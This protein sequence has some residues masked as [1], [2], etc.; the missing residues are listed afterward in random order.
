VAANGRR[1]TLV[2]LLHGTMAG[3]MPQALGVKKASPTR[4]VIAFSGDGGLAM[5]LGDLLTAVQE[6]IPIK[7]VVFN[8]GS[9]GFVE[10]E[11]KVEGMVNAYTDLKNP[12]FARLAEVI[13]FAGWR[14]ETN[15]DLED[16]VKAFLAHPGPA[17]IDV[18]VNRNELVVPPKVEASMVSGTILY[19]A[20]ALLS[21]HG[22]DVIDL[23]ESNLR[24]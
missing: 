11:M 4:Q 5:M 1:R 12:D 10:L 17:L 16:A 2:S 24:R 19:G 9:L 8:N 6:E 3:A 15:A 21:G 23:L 13:G 22:G 7:V 14:V 18:K 20:K